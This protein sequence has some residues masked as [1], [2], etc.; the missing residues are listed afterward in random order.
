MPPHHMVARQA[1][2]RAVAWRRPNLALH[3]LSHLPHLH[4]SRPNTISLLKLVFLLFLPA[5]FDLLAQPIFAAEI[6]GICS[7]V[8]DSSVYPIGILFSEVF[9]EYF[10]TVGDRLSQFACLFYV[11][12]IIFDACLALLQVAIGVPF[13]Y[14]SQNQF[15]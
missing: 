7:P 10:S 5:I 13:I 2:G 1:P 14:L 9:L 11:I 6:W 15:L 4:L 3:L 8:C 12:I